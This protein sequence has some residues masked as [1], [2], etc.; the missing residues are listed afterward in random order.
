MTREE[1]IELLDNLVG[2][3][4]DNQGSDYD[5]ALK[6]AIE[7]LRT[8][9]DTISRQAAIDA[10]AEHE[11]SR[12]H[13]YTLF[14]D[15]VS[16]CAEVIRDLPPTQPDGIPLKWIDKHLKWLDNCDNDFAQLAKVGIRAMVEIWKKDKT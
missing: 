2:M 13:N 14:V 5:D 1:A 9:G 7:A 12:G 10:L 11:K 8:D 16:E 3:V 6:M 15:I 4:E